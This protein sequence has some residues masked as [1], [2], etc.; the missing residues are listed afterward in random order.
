MKKNIIQF[1]KGLS[2]SHFLACYGTE[3]QCRAEF[4]K[5]KWPSGFRCPRCGGERYFEL[6]TRK[7]Y[8]CCACRHQTSLTVGT[9]YEQTKLP[10]KTWFLASYLVTQTKVGISSMNLYQKLG[11]SY[12]SALILK[13]KLQQVMLQK[14]HSEPLTGQILVDDA[15][16]GGELHDD[17]RGRGS[18]NKTP[19]IVA[20]ELSNEGRPQRAKFHRLDNFSKADIV[21]WAKE[22]LIP[23]CEVTSDGLACFNGFEEAGFNHT[24]IITGGGAN[25]MKN[26]LFIW[27]NTILG[28]LKNAL[29]GV[30][31]SMS[32]KHLPRYLAEFE[33][34]FNRRF[35]LSVLF[36][37]LIA[38][39]I[40][41]PPMPCRTL[42]LAEAYW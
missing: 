2:L 6:K 41:T 25:S 38:D 28:N 1:Q 4:F 5:L 42:K 17:K 9:I 37:Q 32:Q 33:Y 8:Q 12:N 14:E 16:W 29:R 30:Y 35:D 40:K 3:E 34:R 26:I 19:F 15:Y 18:P 13:H 23:P 24:A 7:L 22:N 20:I 21:Q 31:H 39:S 27:L 36:K 10:L 11:I